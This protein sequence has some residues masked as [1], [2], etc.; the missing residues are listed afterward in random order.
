MCRGRTLTVRVVGRGFWLTGNARPGLGRALAALE[1]FPEAETDLLEAQRIF[2]TAYG[3]S[4]DRQKRCFEAVIALYTEW[5]KVQPG[6]GHAATAASW[7]A[8]PAAS[9]MQAVRAASLRHLPAR[10]AVTT[11]LVVTEE[12][13]GRIAGERTT[14]EELRARRCN[15]SAA[16]R[17]DQE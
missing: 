13:L 15:A 10:D 8:R 5:D 9:G 11:S 4:K 14:P 3:V 7:R 6:R 1:R 17:E 16:L 12:N 2:S